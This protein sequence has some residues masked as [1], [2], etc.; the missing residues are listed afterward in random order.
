MS[1]QSAWEDAAAVLPETLFQ[2][3]LQIGRERLGQLEELRLR[4]GFPM[5]ALLPG[6]EIETTGP[7]VGEEELR[8]VVE[9]ATQASAHTALDRVRQGFV[10][11]RGEIGRAHV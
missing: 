9:N 11:L 6:G 7:R 4:R 10:T 8:Q 2:G 3:L 1:R 5:T